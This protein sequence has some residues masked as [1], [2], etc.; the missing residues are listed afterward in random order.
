MTTTAACCSSSRHARRRGPPGYDLTLPQPVDHRAHGAAARSSGVRDHHQAH[1]ARPR[2]PRRCRARLRGSPDPAG[3]RGHSGGHRRRD[4]DDA[5]A[6]RRPRRV[7]ARD[8]EGRP[9]P[10][11]DRAARRAER[12]PRDR[13]GGHHREAAVLRLG[14]Q[15]PG[16]PRAGLP[17]RRLEGAVPGGRAGVEVQAQGR[18]HR[19][20]RP[21]GGDNARAGRPQERHGQGP[22]LPVRPRPAPCHRP[23]DHLRRA[24]GGLRVGQRRPARLRRRAEGKRVRRRAGGRAGRAGRR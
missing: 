18:A 20:R 2:P 15:R 12:R 13:A 17:V 6:H 1:G 7:R 19:P 4:R 10:D 8:P 14:D 11:L 21:A 22:L 3:P 5:Q 9:G 24:A 23:G 16:R